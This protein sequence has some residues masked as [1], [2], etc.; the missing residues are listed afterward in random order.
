MPEVD[1]TTEAKN[2]YLDIP[3][4]TTGQF[5]LKGSGALDWGMQNGCCR[6]LRAGT[7]RTV[8]L[9]IDHGYFQGP[10]TGLERVD[11]NILPLVPYADALMCTRGIL[12]STVPS[13]SATPVVLRAS[14]GPSILKELSHEEI[15][16]D[17]DD[18]LRLNIC[19]LAVQVFIGGEFETQ[20]VHNMTRLVDL[21]LRYG[22]PV[23]AGTAVG[24]EIA[25]DARLLRIACPIFAEIQVQFVKTYYLAE[26]FETV[27]ASGPLT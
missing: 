24:T 15:A 6:V 5:Y 3:A 2:F 18:A 21:G 26:G 27:T 23:M 16:I 4:Q 12:R 14:G 9:A 13:F 1:S 10:T 22:M 8:M 7:G 11:V 17:I 20:T 19:A 25:R